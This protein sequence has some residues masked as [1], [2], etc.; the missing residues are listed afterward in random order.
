MVD[1][2]KG[3]AGDRGTGAAAAAAAATVDPNKIEFDENGFI[4]GTTY[5]SVTELIKGN[6]ELKGL[7]DS[8][9]NELGKI[10]KEHEGLKG[11]TETL[12]SLLKENLNKEAG[13]SAGAGT[14]VDY[15]AERASIEKQIQ[16]L[17][18]LAPTYQTSL[19]SLMSKSNRI[20]AAEASEKT[21]AEASTLFRTELTERDAK[22]AQDDFYREN[23]E[24]N[25]PE[26]QTRIREYIAKDRT[27]MSDPLSAF[28]EIQRDD[29]KIANQ[30]LADEN[31]EYKRL[32][33]LNKGKG[34]AGKVITKG[35][36]PGQQV[37]KPAK[38]TG[39]DLDA[40]MANVLQNLNTSA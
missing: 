37:S 20:T 4:P 19:A 32:I 24:F 34:E 33:D 29:L 15:E 12:A 11:Q 36:G 22:K 3:G 8:Q 7:Y 25:T 5:K 14:K 39:K 26:M 18:P 38:V 9:G 1:S 31:A 23:P 27:G 21:L 17:D 6:S 10:R 28:R 2:N 30:K 35:Q 40:G 16:D 13:K